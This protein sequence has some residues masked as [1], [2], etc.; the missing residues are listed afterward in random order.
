MNF[1][2]PNNIEFIDYCLNED[3]GTGDHSSLGAINPKTQAISTLYFKEN[4][5]LA[6]AQLA[7]VILQHV[8]TNLQ[9]NFDVHDGD[10]LSQGQVMGT[11]SGSAHSLLKA[12]R[13]LLNFMQRLSGI[14]TTTYHAVQKTKG[15]SVKLLDTRK[16]TPGLRAFEKWAVS[17][18][19]GHNH[20]F[21]LYDMVM[22]KD[23][24][25][26]SAGGI[27]AALNRT[28]QYL[29]KN[30]LDLKIEV[31][32]RNIEEV[33]EALASNA[34]HR[35][36]LDNFSPS[37]CKVAVALIDKKCETEASGGINMDNIESY[38]QTGVDFISLGFLTH[39][40]KSIDISMKTKL[41]N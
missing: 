36:M 14:A 33:K 13:L 8:D 5:V 6:G 35:I 27:T 1:S 19:G 10:F 26:D 29:T 37:I 3:I 16:T 23:N 31:E 24:H 25:I 17:V 32:T 2:A 22:L 39:S 4:G 28:T 20:R 41:T 18:G 9:I 12:E 11:V 38:A 15:T 7:K 21:G 40:F 34:V 30:N